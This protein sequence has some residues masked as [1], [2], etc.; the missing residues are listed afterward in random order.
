MS[1]LWPS[2]RLAVIAALALHFLVVAFFA[3]LTF[4]PEPLTA[5]FNRFRAGMTVDEVRAIL[6][7]PHHIGV[8]RE[9]QG[10]W[11]LD[12]NG[13]FPDVLLNDPD[14]FQIWSW[15]ETGWDATTSVLVVIM[16]RSVVLTKVSTT[17]LGLRQEPLD[18]IWRLF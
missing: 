3:W 8:M 18:R 16:D 11:R 15:K 2:R 9:A 12:S 7:E 5:K 4:K 13:P 6:G 17:D 1:V 14:L 10:G